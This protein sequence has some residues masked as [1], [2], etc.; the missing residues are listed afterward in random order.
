[1]AIVMHNSSIEK[2]FV[3]AKLVLVARIIIVYG[4]KCQAWIAMIADI[5]LNMLCSDS[6]STQVSQRLRIQS[7][8]KGI[9]DAIASNNFNDCNDSKRYIQQSSSLQ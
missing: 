9:A 4:S 2:P 8:T 6:F 7:F 5:V 1:M 3:Y